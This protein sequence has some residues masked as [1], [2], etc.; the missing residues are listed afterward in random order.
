VGPEVIVELCPPGGNQPVMP[1]LWARLDT[2]LLASPS[3]SV[4]VPISARRFW[5]QHCRNPP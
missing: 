2:F 1:G 3:M 4:P 5:S